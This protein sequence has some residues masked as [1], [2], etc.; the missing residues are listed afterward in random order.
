MTID[1]D[2]LRWDLT[3]DEDLTS[4]LGRAT[5]TKYKTKRGWVY[6]MS[7]GEDKYWFISTSKSPRNSNVPFW[8]EGRFPKKLI[9]QPLF[10]PQEDPFDDVVSLED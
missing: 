3:G 7:Q 10:F 5:I 6:E 1:W 4:W 2:N 9:M 8:I